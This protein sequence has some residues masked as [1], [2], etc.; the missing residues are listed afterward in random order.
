MNPHCNVISVISSDTIS[1]FVDTGLLISDRVP[2]EQRHL[3]IGDDIQRRSDDDLRIGRQFT[4]VV[5]PDQIR[6]VISIAFQGEV[7]VRDDV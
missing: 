5:I 1:A 7:S 6:G 2:A 3:V 4:S